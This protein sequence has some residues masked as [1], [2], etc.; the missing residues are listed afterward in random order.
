MSNEQ[1]TQHYIEVMQAYIAGEAIEVKD[2]GSRGG[3]SKAGT[4]QWNFI[5]REYRIRPKSKPSVDWSALHGDIKYIARDNNDNIFGYTGKPSADGSMNAVWLALGCAAKR[6]D[7]V[8][9][10]L[11]PG[12][13]DWRDSLVERPACK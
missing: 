13:C 2:K 10:S 7:G 1:V 11:T 3:W 6:L 12:D 4:P 9:A 8:I 5:D